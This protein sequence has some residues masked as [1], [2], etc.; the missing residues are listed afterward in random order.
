MLLEF[1]EEEIIKCFK[2][3]M[4]LFEAFENVYL[5]GSVLN[6]QKISNDIDIIL[7]YS[8]FSNTIIKDSKNICHYFENYFKLPIDITLLSCKERQ[9]TMILENI[10][11]IQIK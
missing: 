1:N 7:V 6:S 5:F 8:Q 3:K 11:Y 9:D 4:N 10:N 2:S